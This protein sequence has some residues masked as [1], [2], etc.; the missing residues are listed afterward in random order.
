MAQ[1]AP[2]IS[3]QEAIRRI[4]RVLALEEI[5]LGQAIG[6]LAEMAEQIDDPEQ[7]VLHQQAMDAL[8]EL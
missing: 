2:R 1:D 7:R 4:L 6:I 3:T 8:R 5:T